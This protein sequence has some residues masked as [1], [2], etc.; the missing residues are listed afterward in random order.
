MRAGAVTPRLD[1]QRTL[2]TRALR[3]SGSWGR[4]SAARFRAARP[5][6]R[7]SRSC[8]S[9]EAGGSRTLDRPGKSRVL[10]RLSYG[11]AAHRFALEGGIEAKRC[12]SR[13]RRTRARGHPC[14]SSSRYRARAS[15]ILDSSSYRV[16]SGPGGD[17]THGCRLKRTELYLLSYWPAPSGEP[18]FSMLKHGFVPFTSR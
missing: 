17:R 12:R 6:I 2:G 14:P 10:Y 5:A 11:L 8:R 13:P 7:R 1:C 15:R 3:G 18:R 9:S 4:T 16:P